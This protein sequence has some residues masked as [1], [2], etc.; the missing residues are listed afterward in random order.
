MIKAVEQSYPNLGKLF[1]RQQSEAKA[2]WAALGSAS[3]SGKGKQGIPEASLFRD[4]SKTSPIAIIENKKIGNIAEAREQAWHYVRQANARGVTVPIAIGFDGQALTVDYFDKESGQFA[5]CRLANGKEAS[6]LYRE[7]QSWPSEDELIA[8]ANS[9]DGQIQAQP[10]V[11][12]DKLLG[13]CMMRINETMRDRGVET[14]DRIVVFTAFLVACRDDDFR[15][16]LADVKSKKSA[17]QLG[18][19]VHSA[20]SNQI[21]EVASFDDQVANNLKGFAAYVKPKLVGDNQQPTNGAQ[22]IERIAYRDLR[23]LCAHAGI[24]IE[25]WVERM[26][27][28][29]FNLVDVYE[30]FKAYSPTNDLGQ[31]FTPRQTVRAMIHIAEAMRK[32]PLHEHDVVYDPACGVGGF[33]VGALERV[34]HSKASKEEQAAVKKRFGSRLI[35]CENTSSI[36]HVARVNLWMHGDGTSGIASDSSLE[37]DY[38]AEKGAP[39]THGIDDPTPA[40]HPIDGILKALSKRIEKDS[41]RP[42]LVL[43]NPPFPHSKK[44]YQSFEFVE[45]ALK[46]LEEG[47]M[48]CALVPAT[49]VIAEDQ[50]HGGARKKGKTDAAA[51]SVAPGFRARVLKHAQLLA[52]IGCPA[53]L[54]APGASA[55]TYIIVMKKQSGGHQA[56]Q[57]VLFARCPEDGYQMSKSTNQR[58]SP[59]RPEDCAARRWNKDLAIGGDMAD[60]LFSR[61]ASGSFGANVSWIQQHLDGGV[62][63]PRLAVSKTLSRSDIDSGADWAPE[64]FINDEMDPKE[65]LRLANRIAAEMQAFEL[66]KQV[67]GKW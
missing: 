2:L 15:R 28:S 26:N 42:S 19:L 34:A 1:Q 35:G 30:V 36:A 51:R 57:P 41:V 47:G 22:A 20:I 32:R 53:D 27:A 14:N 61:P 50:A 52:V 48:L 5:P 55:N 66:I 23:E 21:E 13:Q 24:G 45:H 60:L 18:R 10:S 46:Q 62:D 58:M 37:R 25:E 40:K 44:D 6:E 12:E 31:Y 9:R 33:L 56:N 29:L 39:G 49:T 65:L 17:N 4:E 3:K 16:T 54:F 63:V 64:R 11:I 8:F 7:S 59:S 38:L 43:M 67:G